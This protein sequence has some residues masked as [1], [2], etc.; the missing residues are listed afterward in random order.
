MDSNST[1]T[2]SPLERNTPDIQIARNQ[3]LANTG[4]HREFRDRTYLQRGQGRI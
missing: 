4:S 2:V 1:L 3:K